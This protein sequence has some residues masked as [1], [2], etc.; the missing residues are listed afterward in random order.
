LEYPS[1]LEVGWALPT[2]IISCHAFRFTVETREKGRGK[3][4]EERVLGFVS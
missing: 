1:S 2:L 4:E 3:R